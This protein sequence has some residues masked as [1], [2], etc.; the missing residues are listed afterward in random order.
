MMSQDPN[1]EITHLIEGAEEVLDPLECLAD[2]TKNDPGAPF[3]P[4]V[5]A[6]L[7]E[8]RRNSRSAFEALRAQLKK[9]GCRVTALDDAIAEEAGDEQSRGPKQADILIEIAG[10]VDL[11]HTADDAAFADVEVNGHRE[12]WPIRSKGFRAWL[13][14]QFYLQTGGA[15]NS[16]AMQSAMG[17]IDARARFESPERVAH[18]RVGE[19]EGKVYLDLGDAA[20]RAVEIDTM[21]WRIIDR[22][23][24]RF[25]RAAGM[26]ALPEPAVGG[27]INALRQFLNVRTEGDF[28]LT[29]AWLVASLRSK[30]PF[31]VLAV[32]GE[33]GSAKSTFSAIV[34]ALVDPNAAPLRA[35]PRQD[36]ELFIAANNGH[37]LAFDNISGALPSWTSDTLCRLA[38]GG[39]FAKRQLYSDADETI[40]D[41]CRPALLN[42][43]EDVVSRP[44]LADR[45]IFLMLEAISE[46]ARKAEAEIWR[47]FEAER[48]GILGAL[49]DAI[50]KGLERLPHTKLDKR[51]RMADFALWA[52]ACESAL[53]PA[54]T[55]IDAYTG[56][57]AVAVEGVIDADPVASAVRSFARTRVE[58]EGTAAE[59]LT[60]LE[61]EVGEKVAKSKMW[62]GGANALSGRLRRAATFL[63]KAGVDIAF[64]RSENRA[65]TRTIRITAQAANSAPDSPEKSSSASSA[66]SAPTAV[67]REN[68]DLRERPLDDPADDADDPSAKIVQTIV[69]GN[70]LKSRRLDDA[71]DADDLLPAL[72]GGGKKW[73]T[74][75]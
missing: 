33:Q 23:P 17:V 22:P 19:L 64:D 42:G 21:G 20:W 62:P 29:V 7:V 26:K 65:R 55:F 18:L 9:A 35:L 60:A 39:G 11:F 66:S 58:W 44:D 74:R 10:R 53:W 49:L 45:S 24:V 8:L 56:N 57:R 43:I 32:A 41:A 54:G 34:R 75:I 63:R 46:E 48:P 25:R 70:P 37:V 36:E 59:L 2:R 31:P 13:Y 6:A 68:N 38:T 16:E 1:F 28:V 4:D 5:L 52:T 3:Q 12:T 72:A 47:D 15:P 30:G 27:S 61:D 73:S 14:R 67:P 40:F 51:P 50:S 69:R 71:D